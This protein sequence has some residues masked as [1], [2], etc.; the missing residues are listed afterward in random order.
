MDQLIIRYIHTD[1]VEVDLGQNQLIC[2]DCKEEIPQG[3]FPIIGILHPDKT[4]LYLGFCNDKHL[5]R[6]LIANLAYNTPKE[7]MRAIRKGMENAGN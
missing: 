5:Q 2:V 1:D 6:W 3:E 4:S 7:M